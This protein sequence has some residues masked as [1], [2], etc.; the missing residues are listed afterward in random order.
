MRKDMK[1]KIEVVHHIKGRARIKI[2]SAYDPR[3][4]FM[5]LEAILHK[6]DE[7]KKAELNTHAGSITI[8]FKEKVTLSLILEKLKTILLSLTSDP[9][10]DECLEEIE[11]AVKYSQPGS[12][13]V[14]LQDKMFGIKHNVDNSVENGTGQMMDMKTAI[15][16]TAFAAGLATLLLAPALPTPTWLVLFVFS[17]TSF[18]QLNGVR[19]GARPVDTSLSQEHEHTNQPRGQLAYDISNRDSREASAI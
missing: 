9:L 5:V 7:V 16:G 18:T 15:P 3:I 6:I 4:F 1:I 10:F 8:Y 14:V 19:N 12:V 13:S 11:D 2:G 17:F